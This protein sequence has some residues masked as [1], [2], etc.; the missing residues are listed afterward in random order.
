M[1]AQPAGS[2]PRFR[3]GMEA[4]ARDLGKDPPG[5]QVATRSLS[6][7]VA[8]PPNQDVAAGSAWLC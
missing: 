5:P 3:L 4:A 1:V 7:T 8:A 2:F 6:D